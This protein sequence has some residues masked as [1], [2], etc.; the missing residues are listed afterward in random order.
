MA[1]T[2]SCPP[3]GP[4]RLWA[5]RGSTLDVH[6]TVC[7]T[8]A[9]ADGT[10]RKSDVLN[11][12]LDSGLLAEI[13]R[14]SE[15]RGTSASEMARELMRHGVA[16]ERQL[17]AQELHRPYDQ[18]KIERDPDRGYLRIEARWVWFSAKELAERQAD[19]DELMGG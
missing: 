14:M 9:M 4:S 18:T 3:G 8:A 16:V 12:R 11:L 2:S 10:D 1:C 19:L 6:Y 13:Q 5:L 7:Y 17:E 15:W